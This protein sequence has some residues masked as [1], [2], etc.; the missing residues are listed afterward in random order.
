MSIFSTVISLRKLPRTFCDT[1]LAIAS[2]EDVLKGSGGFN[3]APKERLRGTEAT[4]F[5]AK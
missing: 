5:P 2:H 1:F 4:S 3:D